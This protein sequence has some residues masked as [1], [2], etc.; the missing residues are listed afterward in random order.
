MWT[1]K[2]GSCR[3]VES[4]Y[5]S[6]YTQPVPLD[7]KKY[8]RL[9]GT[10]PDNA[11]AKRIGCTVLSVKKRRKKL[12]VQAYGERMNLPPTGCLVDEWGTIWAIEDWRNE[13]EVEGVRTA[14]ATLREKA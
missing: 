3:V 14:E 11:V 6:R 7:W 4:A 8:D 13:R 2:S 1:V 9:L 5:P 10:M 12:K